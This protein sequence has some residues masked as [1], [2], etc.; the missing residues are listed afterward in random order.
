MNLKSQLIKIHANGGL[1]DEKLIK[2]ISDYLGEQLSAQ[3]YGCNIYKDTCKIVLTKAEKYTATT[4]AV[5][6]S[7]DGHVLCGDNYTYMEIDNGQYMMA[8]EK[9]KE[10]MM[11]LRRLS[12]Y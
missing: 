12:I 2:I 5:S 4:Q 6:L 8:W 11:N 1:C 9:G 7:R 10:P 3:K